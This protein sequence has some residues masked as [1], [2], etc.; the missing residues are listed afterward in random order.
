MVR[1]IDTLTNVPREV[2][3]FVS[4]IGRGTVMGKENRFS[5]TGFETWFSQ[6]CLRLGNSNTIGERLESTSPCVLT[7]YLNKNILCHAMI[8]V[9]G[10]GG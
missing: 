4:D 2:Y 7:R 8:T 6:G 3:M 1:R 5:E 9:V 10:N